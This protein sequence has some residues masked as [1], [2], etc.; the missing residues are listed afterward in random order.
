MSLSPL[1]YLWV[2]LPSANRS[3]G[4]G[5]RREARKEKERAGSVAK[6]AGGKGGEGSGSAVVSFFALRFPFGYRPSLRRAMSVNTAPVCPFLLEKVPLCTMTLSTKKLSSSAPL[7]PF[8]ANCEVGACEQKKLRQVVSPPPFASFRR[9]RLSLSVVAFN[10][11][12][13]AGRGHKGYSSVGSAAAAA[14]LCRID[15][16]TS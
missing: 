13:A 5:R 3:S 2:C 11:P 15:R 6:K 4:S 8:T 10:L 1:L 7:P 16:L 14:A 12:A 9:R